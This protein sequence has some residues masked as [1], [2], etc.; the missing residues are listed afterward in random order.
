MLLEETHRLL[1]DRFASDPDRGRGAEEVQQ[2]LAL[3]AT[4][5]GLEQRGRL[6][7]AAVAVDPE[8]RQGYFLFGFA[9]GF[10]LGLG[11]AFGFGL[12]LGFAAAFG[13]AFATGF[14]AAGFVAAGRS[15][16]GVAG[17]R[18]GW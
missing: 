1:V 14:S 9:L 8:V 13:L 4:A 12:G 11:F 18:G 3:A 17:V 16:R 5:T 7:P 15:G 6:V 2:A 10:G